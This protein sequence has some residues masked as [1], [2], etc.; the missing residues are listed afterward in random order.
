M[1]SKL[2][3]NFKIQISKSR[4]HRG[5]PDFIED[6]RWRRHRD[7]TES[8]QIQNPNFKTVIDGTWDTYH[9]LMGEFRFNEVLAE[10]WGLMSVCDKYIEEERPWEEGKDN[11]EEVI[12]ELLVALGNI[13]RMLE[14][15]LPQTSEEIFR[16]LGIFEKSKEN[17]EFQVTVGPS[18]FPRFDTK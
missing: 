1:A 11:R 12:G 3:P 14:P 5:S 4:F 15:V 7:S 16:R 18:L 9:R 10:I 6:P 17:W 8:G 13:A 2:N